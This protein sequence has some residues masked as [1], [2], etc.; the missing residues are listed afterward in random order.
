VESTGP[1]GDAQNGRDPWVS[2]V[3]RSLMR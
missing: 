1:A 3:A 2:R